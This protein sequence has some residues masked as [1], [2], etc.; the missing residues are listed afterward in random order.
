MLV[1][2]VSSLAY[3]VV[4]ATWIISMDYWI[5]L[6]WYVIVGDHVTSRDLIDQLHYTPAY[7]D[8]VYMPGIMWS[9]REEDE[10]GITNDA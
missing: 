10:E 6:Q 7:Q 4:I 9:I 8:Y 3:L 1:H 5:T 2:V